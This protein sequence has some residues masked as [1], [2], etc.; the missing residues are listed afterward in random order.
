M[1]DRFNV[2]LVNQGLRM[3]GQR[4]L[5]A[6]TFFQSTGH[7][8]TEELHLQVKKVAPGIG[9]ATVYRT[10]KL[11]SEAGLAQGR[12]FGDSFAR[13][14]SASQNGHHDHLV[15]TKCGKIIE[16]ENDRIEELQKAVAR[17]HGYHITDHKLELY[18]ICMK[19]QN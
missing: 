3:T 12:S 18:G 6:R 17:K 8:S 13:Y 2:F 5:I 15:C 10:I 7:I 9:F 11:L 4:E 19:C 16:F 1:L 14:E